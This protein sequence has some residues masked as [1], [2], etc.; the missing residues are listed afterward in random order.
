MS[1]RF[2]LQPDEEKSSGAVVAP[3]RP[4]NRAKL[5]K[6]DIYSLDRH[7]SLNNHDIPNNLD[8][9]NTAA[10]ISSKDHAGDSD[11]P[12]LRTR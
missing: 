7:D 2:W 5:H 11:G 10:S 9:F 12:S 3:A 4:H 8:I 6:H 1:D